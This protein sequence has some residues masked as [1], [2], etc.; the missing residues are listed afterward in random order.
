LTDSVIEVILSTMSSENELTSMT[1]S[2]PASLKA[3]VKARASATG[4]STPSE[5]IRRLIRDDQK[6]HEQDE[7]ERALLEG[8]GSSVREMTP[9]AWQEL[10]ET[11]R[12]KLPKGKTKRRK[13]Q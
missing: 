2:L 1:V 7:L 11:L 10:R 5:Y 9:E 13:A 3:Y 8:L 6:A 4:C 12:E